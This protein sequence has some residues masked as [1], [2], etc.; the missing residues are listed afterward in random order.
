MKEIW[1]GW[2]TVEGIGTG[3]FSKVYKIRKKDTGDTEEYSAALKIITI[4]QSPE[5]Y[6]SYA[7]EGY[8]ED[9]ITGIFTSQV[10]RIVEEFRL[11]AQFKGNSNIVSYE[12]HMIVP[13]EDG[14]GW[15]ILIRMELLTSL[16]KHCNQTG[17]SEEETV[18]LGI[19]ICHALELC[20][21]KNI[22]HRDIK[23]QNI[24]VNEFGD[25][26]LGDFGIAKAM[27]HTTHATK[28]GTY[29]Y[30]A[31]EI[32]RGEAYGATID[33]YSLGLVLYWLLN[34]RRLPFLPLPPEAPTATQIE[35][36]CTRRLSGEALPPPKNGSDELKAIVL[37]ACAY[38]AL[39]RYTTP[40]AM[41]KDLEK[42]L[43]AILLTND[44]T[45]G[46]FAD[47]EA[48]DFSQNTVLLENEAEA[49]QSLYRTEVNLT[50]KT[51]ED[52]TVFVPVVEDPDAGVTVGMNEDKTVQMSEEHLD[53]NDSETEDKAE[54]KSGKGKLFAILGAILLTAIVVILLLLRGCDE[55]NASPA[56]TATS[57]TIT[58]TT[59]PETE[60]PTPPTHEHSKT[61]DDWE[62]DGLSH[63]YVCECGE[64]VEKA[65]HTYGEWEV[66][67]D[68]TETENGEKVRSCLICSFKETDTIPLKAHEH[69]YAE[70]WSDNET[71]HWYECSCGEKTAT[72]AHSFGEWNITKHSTET[73]TGTRERSCVICGHQEQGIV[74]IL[75]HVHSYAGSFVKNETTHWH[76][77]ECG[78]KADVAAHT[79]GAW[80]VTNAAT[81]TTS[82]SQMHACV[83]CGY[84]ESQTIQPTGHTEVADAAVAAT[85]TQSGLTAGK[86]CSVCDTVLVKQNMIAATGHALVTDA[87]VAPTCINTGLTEGKHCSVCNT[88]TVKQN[89]VAATG[90]HTYIDGKCTGC[91][92]AE[93][94]SEGLEYELQADNTYSVIG[95]GTCTDTD[96][97]IPST[98]NGKPVTSISEIAFR[99]CDG[100]TSITIPN[101]VTSIGDYAFCQ[102]DDLTSITI[103]SSVTSIGISA[104]GDCDKLTSLS[105]ASDNT[106]YHS[107]NNCIIQTKT[108]ELVAGCKNSVIPTDGSVTSIGNYAFDSCNGLTSIEIPDSVTSI[109]ISAFAI[110]HN[111]TSITIP[112][113]VTSIGD[114]AFYCCSGLTSITI[115][116]G[117]TSIGDYA[118]K[119]CSGLTSISIP[120]SV[121]SIGNQVF[122]GCD[123]LTSITIPSS[124]TS[125]GNYAFYQCHGLTSI[126]IPN[127]VADIG[128]YAFGYCNNLTTIYCEAS[129]KPSGW[130]T[131]WLDG[132]KATVYWG[133]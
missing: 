63:W 121:T 119:Q 6:E 43:E 10:K 131:S 2:E 109:G 106:V 57:E 11:M 107:R 35:E 105:V 9:T 5:E 90:V 127:S 126:T 52:R 30:M 17:L 7:M 77:C 71:S 129:S 62:T 91:G 92:D 98:Y 59:L 38:S 66:V 120:S 56:T 40:T 27:D 39:D 65:E 76:A 125:I 74:P 18:K 69:T 87:A 13:H 61:S 28:T 49:T 118:F 20:Q 81:C 113:G 128:Y 19:D 3:G 33:I 100:L 55:E 75:S 31:P 102:C 51:V 99:F 34:E 44:A 53:V 22:I 86:H 117:V 108:K 50:E 133:Q 94:A 1:P 12:D 84:T 79:F 25:Y 93:K 78:E 45:V 4:P 80:T 132:C 42:E 60:E 23:P 67:K 64:A 72:A 116:D 104:F 46:L 130:D 36:S 110:C 111:L 15:D 37:K 41:R 70:T 122:Y 32:Y 103:P 88:V 26:K 112:D 82:G 89:T 73:T 21:K 123:C 68:A 8:D 97:V 114:Y 14:K 29:S 24:F 124:V 96:V 115:P 95:I 58:T 83:V 101:S 85:C 16:P 47:A 48:V 54:K